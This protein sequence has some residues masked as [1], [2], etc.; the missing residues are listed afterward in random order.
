MLPLL[1]ADFQALSHSLFLLTSGFP[2][3]SAVYSCLFIQS[4][5]VISLHL[6][7]QPQS[8]SELFFFFPLVPLLLVPALR[9]FLSCLCSVNL[10]EKELAL[11]FS[12][13]LCA[14]S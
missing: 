5:I 12:Q 9:R 10:E 7:I 1:S 6:K 8:L 2:L 4:F 14:V 3:S 13:P 11:D